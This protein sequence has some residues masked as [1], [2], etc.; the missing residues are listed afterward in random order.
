MTQR[1]LTKLAIL[2]ILIEQAISRS[3]NYD[4][5]INKFAE[6]NVIKL[7]FKYVAEKTFE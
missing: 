3:I 4:E 2:N 7:I 5:I 6:K 1:R